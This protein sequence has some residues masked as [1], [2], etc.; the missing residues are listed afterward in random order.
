MSLQLSSFV[1]IVSDIVEYNWFDPYK[2]GSSYESIGTGFFIDDNGYILTCSHVVEDAISVSII[3]PSIGKDKFKAEIISLCPKDDLALLKAVNYKNTHYLELGDSDKIK[4]KDSV[5]VVGYPL[6][7]DRLKYTSGIVSGLQDS[8]IQTDAPINAGNSGGPLLDENNKVVG[9]N[10]SKIASFIADNIGYCIPIYQFKLLKD[11]MYTGNVKLIHKPQLLCQFNNTDDNISKYTKSKCLTGYMV[12]KIYDIS[13][14]TTSGLDAGDILCQFDKYKLDNYGE[15]IV[16]WSTQK[17]H[18]TEL[19]NRYKIG[20]TLQLVFWDRDKEQIQTKNITFKN[21]DP[22]K[23]TTK[24]PHFEK[25]DYEIINGMIVCEL[26]LNHLNDGTIHLF[27]DDIYNDLVGFLE[28]ENRTKNA[29]IITDILGGSYAKKLNNIKA[30]EILEKVNNMEV[31]NLK[32]FREAILKP[33]NDLVIFETK[34]KNL[35]INDVSKIVSEHI[36]LADKHVYNILPLFIQFKSLHKP[37]V[38]GFSL[39]TNNK[40]ILIC[41]FIILILINECVLIKN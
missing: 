11:I 35:F 1:R 26:T 9:V 28:I 41:I 19:I 27:E 33:V 3:I 12:K 29:L 10:S 14:L 20:D 6:G 37:V 36:F 8:L 24:Y 4:P 39:N 30:G 21:E 31:E 25:M 15:C 13:P 17:V 7:Q 32:E 38:E 5:T 40:I 18:I 16:P 2:K 34:K 22:F 23:I